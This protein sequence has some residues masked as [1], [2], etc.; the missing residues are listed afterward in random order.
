LEELIFGGDE[1]DDLS[2]FAD[3]DLGE[4]EEEEDDLKHADQSPTDIPSGIFHT[5]RI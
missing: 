1:D 5:C 4:L 2:D 3:E